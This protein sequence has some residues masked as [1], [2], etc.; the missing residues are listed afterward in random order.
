MRFFWYLIL[1]S[2]TT[3]FA[4]SSKIKYSNTFS[5][6]N[7]VRVSLIN[8]ALEVELKASEDATI[9]FSV[10]PYANY[11]SATNNEGKKISKIVPYIMPNI[12]F[13]DYYNMRKR[14]DKGKNTAHNSANYMGL[15]V[16]YVPKVTTDFAKL[17]Y[18]YSGPGLFAFWGMNRVYGKH[19]LVD[20]GIGAQFTI[21][22]V[23]Y[24]SG[25]KA[26]PLINLKVG[27]NLNF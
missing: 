24:D 26:N 25:F 17:K 18:Q 7:A 11:L 15:G 9:M 2:S 22:T 27:Y 1:L 4:Q 21:N 20:L 10:M 14:Y 6:E 13:R 8:P 12:S 3:V 5:S 23:G 19:L 16:F